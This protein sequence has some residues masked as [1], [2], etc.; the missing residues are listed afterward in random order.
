MSKFMSAPRTRPSL[1]LC[2]IKNKLH[3]ILK[4]YLKLYVGVCSTFM[5]IST[6]LNNSKLERNIYMGCLKS[7]SY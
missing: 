2:T 3:I 5:T 1:S 6:L 7:I 4:C